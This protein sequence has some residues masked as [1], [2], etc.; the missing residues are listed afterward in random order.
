MLVLAMLFARTAVAEELP[1]EEA[2][3]NTAAEEETSRFGN[4]LA[5]PIFITE[6][7][8]GEGLGLGLVYFHNDDK[9]DTPV[10]CRQARRQ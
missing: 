10:V 3:Q 7:A 6:P 1:Q 8:I 5:L 9:A 2:R 4:F